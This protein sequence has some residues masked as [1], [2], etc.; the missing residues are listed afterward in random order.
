MKAAL[1]LSF[2]G[3]PLAVFGWVMMLFVCGS[4]PLQAE[5]PRIDANALGFSPTAAAAANVAALQRALDGGDKL[6][7]VTTPGV[8]DLDATVWLDS[9]TRLECSP[10]VVFRKTSTYSFVLANRG[11]QTRQWNEGIVIDGLENLVR[12]RRGPPKAAPASMPAACSIP[13]VGR[14][15]PRF[16]AAMEPSSNPCRRLP[17][18]RQLIPVPSPL[19][20]VRSRSQNATDLRPRARWP[21]RSARVRK[22]P[23]HSILRPDPLS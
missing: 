16:R 13:A 20:P 22:T 11:I 6:V 12:C 8:Y 2:S 17:R 23:S 21:S 10:G 19:R 18:V 7:T 1:M 15:S 3:R 4:Q 5:Q 14:P 9:N